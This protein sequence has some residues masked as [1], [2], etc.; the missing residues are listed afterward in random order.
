MSDSGM[1]PITFSCCSAQNNLAQSV[2][3]VGNQLQA[4]SLNCGWCCWRIQ[5]TE[6]EYTCCL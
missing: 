2:R 6:Q 5:N 3:S 4:I 1:R